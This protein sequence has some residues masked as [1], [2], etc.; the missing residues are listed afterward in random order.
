MKTVQD[1]I[2]SILS[3]RNPICL[4]ELSGCVW[5]AVEYRAFGHPQTTSPAFCSHGE[6]AT[7]RPCLV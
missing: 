3:F 6:R 5:M 4:I 2:R 1:G 7:N